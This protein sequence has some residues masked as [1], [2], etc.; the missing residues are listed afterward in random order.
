M[1][2]TNNIS[3]EYG[4]YTSYRVSAIGSSI[5]E[6]E[7][8]TLMASVNTLIKH[9]CGLAKN[10]PNFI[11]YDKGIYNVKHIYDLQIEM[12]C[13][14][15]QLQYDNW[16]NKCIGDNGSYL[17]YHKNSYIADAIKL[18]SEEKIKI[19][20]HDTINNKNEHL[21]RGGK[22][23]IRTILGN[24]EYKKALPSLKNKGI[25]FLDQLL[26]YDG[27][28]LLKWKHLCNEQQ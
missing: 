28:K 23:E 16:I 24:K 3:V 17:E 18:L 9:S 5:K 10:T 25:L 2:K 21:I 6:K 4:N 11:L 14:N 22:I 7:C 8:E 27:K 20:E 1:I 19:C 15:F 12:L 26:E 13:K